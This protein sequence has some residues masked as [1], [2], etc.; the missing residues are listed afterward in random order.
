MTRAQYQLPYLGEGEHGSITRYRQGCRCDAC[1]AANAQAARQRAARARDA[2]VEIGG[3]VARTASHCVGLEGA[4]CPRGRRLYKN[5]LGN[6]C[7]ECRARLAWNGLVPAAPARRHL[8]SLSQQ[9]VGM[10]AIA[11]ATDVSLN[12]L[13]GI[14]RGERHNVRASIERRIL[15]AD[16]GAAADRSLIPAAPTW[17]RVRR[18]MRVHGFTKAQISARIGHDGKRLQLGRHRITARNAHLIERLL[19][20]AEGDFLEGDG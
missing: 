9:G 17:R 12:V 2:L 19:A 14:V 20:D 10:R 7:A 16:A 15:Q 11:D 8:Q 6:L 3:G 13:R 18:L 4:P 1:R 5:S